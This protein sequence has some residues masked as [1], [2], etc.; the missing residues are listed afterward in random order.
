MQFTCLNTIGFAD[1]PKEQ[2]SRANALFSVVAQMNV[3]MGIAVGAIALQMAV[4]MRGDVGHVQVA[5]FHLAFW[6]TAIF[7]V[8]PLYDCFRLDKKAGAVVSGHAKQPE[9]AGQTAGASR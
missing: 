7:A 3:G 4:L 1:V 8:L 2:L 5:D 9:P 6:L